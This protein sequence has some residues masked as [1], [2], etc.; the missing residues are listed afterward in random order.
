MVFDHGNGFMKIFYDENCM[1]QNCK[2]IYLNRQH[3]ILGVSP[4]NSYFSEKN[5]LLLAEW[6]SKSFN[7]FNIFV[8]DTLPIH[9]FLAL[10]YEEARA[11]NK[12]KR[13]VTYLNNKIYKALSNL[14]YSNERIEEL[15]INISCLKNNSNYVDLKSKCY[16]LY[17]NDLN[18]QRECNL[19]TNW[20]LSGHQKN[21]DDLEHKHIAVRYLLDE[22]PLFINTPKILDIKT[23]MFVYHQ[24]PDFIHYLYNKASCNILSENQGFIQVN[25][26]SNVEAAPSELYYGE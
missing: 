22:M 7:N 11:I 5:I 14:G 4:F 13:Q 25:V 16:D 12:T 1:S 18:F 24:S 21:L 19:A 20:V 17:N 10:G 23:S 26:R 8:P 2:K 15:L 6:A 9:T 3:A